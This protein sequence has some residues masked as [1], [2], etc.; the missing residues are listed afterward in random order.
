MIVAGLLVGCVW[1]GEGAAG[2]IAPMV[3]TG[4]ATTALEAHAGV[5]G[6][7]LHVTDEGATLITI[8]FS[9]KA[10]FGPGEVMLAAAPEA[11]VA[12]DYTR[13]LPMLCG[14]VD[15]AQIEFQSG[16][17]VVGGLSP[18]LR[19]GI[20]IPLATDVLP[21]SM[22]IEF[23]IGY[24]N[25]FADGGDVYIGALFGFGLTSRSEPFRRRAHR[26]AL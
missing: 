24:T 19:P 12:P 13:I 17:V 21:P 9:A 10:R 11:C 20:S 2:V 1:Y 22:S 18:Y 3:P 7:K 26:H 8:G 15:L 14:G 23:P 16:D 6:D 4:P 5:S 25:R